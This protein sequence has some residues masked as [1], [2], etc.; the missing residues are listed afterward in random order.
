MNI[1]TDTD[2]ERLELC[3]LEDILTELRRRI[4]KADARPARC[5]HYWG[6]LINRCTLLPDHDGEHIFGISESVLRDWRA[7]S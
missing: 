6:Q 4:R 1:T 7:G 2:Q 5:A 3:D